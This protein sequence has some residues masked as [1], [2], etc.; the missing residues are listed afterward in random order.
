MR[1]RQTGHVAKLAAMSTR[2]HHRDLVQLLDRG[3]KRYGAFLG[4]APS[5][6]SVAIYLGTMSLPHELQRLVR[7]AAA[8]RIPPA[9]RMPD[10]PANKADFPKV[11]AIDCNH[12]VALAKVHYHR[13]TDAVASAALD[14]IRA[15]VSSGRLV[16]A[17][18]FINAFEAMK[19]S[20]EG[21]RERLVRF[22]VSET[23]AVVFRPFRRIGAAEIRTAI[24]RVYLSRPTPSVRPLVFGRGMDDLMGPPRS[25]T[26][27]AANAMLNH[28]GLTEKL[29][30]LFATPA[31]T[32]A[33]ILNTFR[34]RDTIHRELDGAQVM[35]RAR[36][37]DG[38]LPVKE[39][40]RL[41]L[42]N[43]W[44]GRRGQEVQTVLDELGIPRETFSAWLSIDEH[45]P[46]FWD[47][48]PSV[49]VILELEIASTKQRDRTFEANDF[50]DMSFYEAAIP[51]ANLVLT[52][53]YWAERIRHA[54]LHQRYETRVLHRLG[55]LP[56]VLT[57]EKCL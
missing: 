53:T 25:E 19:R 15:A 9:P 39:R 38:A 50:R 4:G 56:S 45:L 20:D 52:E 31:G 24:E 22:M 30:A 13:S 2:A 54:K 26:L 42:R 28:L 21:A 51:Y 55:D 43:Q 48:I 23:R 40:K 14:A 10:L 32:T 29:E 37:A 11:L 7:E 5:L 8:G 57:K 1:R 41:E 6:V 17:L 27:N 33:A 3:S 35:N 34:G 16:V 47:A 46:T 12:W 44:D 36:L 18:H 49:Q